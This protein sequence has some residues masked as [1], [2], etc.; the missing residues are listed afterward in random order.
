V[1]LPAA[2]RGKTGLSV[3]MVQRLREISADLLHASTN[4][5]GHCHPVMT[6]RKPPDRLKGREQGACTHPARD[7]TGSPSV[8]LLAQA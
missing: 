7:A 3:A 6:A 8:A 5:I 4:L 1:A 2:L